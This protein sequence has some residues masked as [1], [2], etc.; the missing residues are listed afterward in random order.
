MVL[1]A[2]PR[3]RICNNT[4]SRNAD[5]TDL[6]FSQGRLHADKG[7][8]QSIVAKRF[9]VWFRYPNLCSD[10]PFLSGSFSAKRFRSTLNYMSSYVRDIPLDSAVQRC[11]TG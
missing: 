7:R 1:A 9:P 8:R 10:S 11:L 2:N 3:S 4:F 6:L 5:M